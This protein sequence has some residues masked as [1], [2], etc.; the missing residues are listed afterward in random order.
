MGGLQFMV[1]RR[2]VIGL[3][4]FNVVQVLLIG[5]PLY[6]G[7]GWRLAAAVHCGLFV[8]W[9]LHNLLFGRWDSID[10]GVPLLIVAVMLAVLWPTLE[11]ARRARKG[12]ATALPSLFPEYLGQGE[13][14]AQWPKLDYRGTKSLSS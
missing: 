14:G 5:A 13:K 11:R 2:E 8:V 6:C 9:L 12:T 4:C 7:L 10:L 1:N 3:I